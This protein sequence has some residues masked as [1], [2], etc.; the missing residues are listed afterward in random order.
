MGGRNENSPTMADGVYAIVNVKN[1]KMY[2]G[3][4]C[5]F[6][7]RWWLH[8]R[9]LRANKHHSPKLQHAWNKYG[10]DAFEFV[11]VHVVDDRRLLL[12]AEQLYLDTLRPDYNICL[13]AGSRYGLKNSADHKERIKT[14]LNAPTMKAK[15]S[16]IRKGKKQSEEHRAAIA[17]AMRGKTNG[18]GNPGMSP[19]TRAR[20]DETRRTNIAAGVTKPRE[21]TTETRERI[22]RAVREH[23]AKNPRNTPEWKEIMR[24]AGLKAAA[25]REAEHG[26]SASKLEREQAVRRGTPEFAAKVS[27]AKAAKA[28]LLT[29]EQLAERSAAARRGALAAAEVIRAKKAAGT[30]K[31][32][33]PEQRERYRQGTLAYNAR[34]DL[35]L[36]L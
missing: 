27:A 3:S 30:A 2:I 36:G 14:A 4:A 26:P 8:R 34:K 22:R 23:H 17:E 1:G 31:V 20:A 19:E 11:I 9:D 35:E 25:N 13:I 18:K 21:F 12:S 29:P 10:E 15:M 16:E 6:A 5:R 24:Q 7:N 28:A 32:R 33:T